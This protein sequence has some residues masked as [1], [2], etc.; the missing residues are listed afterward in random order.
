MKKITLLLLV[1]G[2]LSGCAT[3]T[4]YR[5]YQ[6]SFF[7]S[8]GGYTDIKLQDG[9]YRVSFTG[10]ADTVGD[11]SANF[12]MLR[13]A[14]VA[15]RDGY[16]YF[17][18]SSDRTETLSSVAPYRNSWASFYNMPVSTYVIQC[19]KEKPTTTAVIYNAEEIRRNI[20]AQYGM[21]DVSEVRVKTKG[22]S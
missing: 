11:R 10:N 18:I 3:P 5:P 2:V 16:P 12:A 14:E 8:S 19:F 17:V 9:V 22:Y 15:L 21:K 6:D 4:A 1:L 13:C 20:K 7:E